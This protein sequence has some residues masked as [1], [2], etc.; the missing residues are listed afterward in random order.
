[1]EKTNK[2]KEREKVLDIPHPSASTLIGHHETYEKLTNILQSPKPHH[3]IIIAGPKGIGKTTLIYNVLKNHLQNYDL[4][5]NQQ[6]DS[7]AMLDSNT[8][9]DLLRIEAANNKKG[10]MEEITIDQIR[11]LIDFTSL[12]PSYL[13][14]KYIIIDSIDQLNKS[15]TNA[16]LKILEEPTSNVQFLMTCHNTKAIIQTVISRCIVLRCNETSHE[17][18]IKILNRIGI[19]ENIEEIAKISQNNTSNA[20]DIYRAN[21]LE[22]YR[23]ILSDINS[24]YNTS[25]S[26]LKG[27]KN[28]N[29]IE[30]IQYLFERIIISITIL[31]SGFIKEETMLDFE[32][33]SFKEYI[34]TKYPTVVKMSKKMDQCMDLI[35]QAKIFNIS[36]QHLIQSLLHIIRQ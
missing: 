30:M 36:N 25:D 4:K 31:A 17:D 14:K 20:I 22:F 2:E 10:S 9:P 32:M 28:I 8:H 18:F 5:I 19:T 35:K 13:D 26:F 15:S 3:A 23:A 11:N 7:I 16:I 34:D 1:M 27:M 21:G 6:I 33:E 24:K 29:S 12:T